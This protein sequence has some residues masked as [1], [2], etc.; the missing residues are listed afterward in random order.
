MFGY[1]LVK[2]LERIE[3][4]VTKVEGYP[5]SHKLMLLLQMDA[6]QSLYHFN[7]HLAEHFKKFPRLNS[8]IIKVGPHYFRTETTDSDILDRQYRV[9]L[10][11]PMDLA[12]V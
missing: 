7:K 10:D 9:L 11:S 3:R 12:E 4:S 5:S 1:E 8:K 6:P 2:D